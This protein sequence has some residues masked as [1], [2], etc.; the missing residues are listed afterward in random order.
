PT[1]QSSAERGRGLFKRNSARVRDAE[2]L[3]P[4]A[5]VV[6]HKFLT[7]ARKAFLAPL[8]YFP[9]SIKA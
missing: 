1:V 5:L 4:G 3:S 9:D 6:L 2:Y 7:L 8:P